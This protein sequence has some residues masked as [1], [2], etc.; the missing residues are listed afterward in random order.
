MRPLKPLARVLA[1]FHRKVVAQ[2]RILLVAASL[3]CAVTVA[4]A[5]GGTPYVGFTAITDTVGKSAGTYQIKLICLPSANDVTV[6]YTVTGGT[7]AS[8]ADYTIMAGNSGTVV[9]PAGTTQQTITVT[10][11]N[12]PLATGDVTVTLSLSGPTN[13]TLSPSYFFTLTIQNP[14]P[15]PPAERT[16][17]TAEYINQDV[18][19]NAVW[20]TAPWVVFGGSIPSTADNLRLTLKDAGGNGGPAVSY[21]WSVAAANPAANYPPPGN[22][23]IWDLGDLKPIPGILNFTCVTTFQEGQT[24]TA[25]FP[26]EVGIRSD[27]AIVVGWINQD[28]VVLPAPDTAIV[29]ATFPP[30]G[31]VTW[32]SVPDALVNLGLL[33]Q[34]FENPFPPGIMNTFNNNDRHYLLN[35]LFRYPANPDPMKIAP[36][37]LTNGVLDS[38]KVDA[39][40]AKTWAYK[41][42]NHFQVKFRVDPDGGKYDLFNGGVVK[43]GTV[44]IGVTVDVIIN[45]PHPGQPGPNNG[46]MRVTPSAVAQINDD[47]LDGT[48]INILNELLGDARHAAPAI[49]WENIGSRITFTPTSTVPILTVQ[50]YPSYYWYANGNAPTLASDQQAEPSAHFIPS[51]MLKG[52]AYPYGINPSNGAGTFWGSLGI[53]VPGGRNGDAQSPPDTTSRI[54]AYVAP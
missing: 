54:P 27:D 41:L 6:Q 37:F 25:T 10:L 47:S 46:A 21:V 53:L 38:A 19:T 34:F 7:A 8:P 11:S 48:G 50:D 45:F 4:L 18:P 1:G 12:N 35:W 14:V 52:G 17:I 29:S 28:G 33:S 15:V 30:N 32:E 24:A 16:S 36:D 43:A 3:L 20:E 42:F 9:F 49:F 2:W 22:V 44:S 13:A 51:N 5:Q 40:N 26:I 39:F 23:T 31:V